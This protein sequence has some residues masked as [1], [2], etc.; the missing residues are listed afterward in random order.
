MCFLWKVN[1]TW[2]INYKICLHKCK[3]LVILIAAMDSQIKLLIIFCM[4]TEMRYKSSPASIISQLTLFDMGGGG[5]YFNFRT[6]K[7][8][9]KCISVQV[10]TLAQILFYDY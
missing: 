5:E 2:M 8:S 1:N 3:A 4:T 6:Q 7:V 10:S 9:Q